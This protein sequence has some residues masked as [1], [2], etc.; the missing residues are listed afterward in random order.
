MLSSLR[1]LSIEGDVIDE[2]RRILQ[3]QAAHL[4][5][6]MALHSTGFQAWFEEV[7]TSIAPTIM[8]TRNTRKK[9]QYKQRAKPSQN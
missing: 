7:P 8:K 4:L 2:V 6:Q 9:K 3:S 1:I 5:S